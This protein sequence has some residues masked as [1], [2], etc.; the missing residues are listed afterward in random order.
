MQPVNRAALDPRCLSTTRPQDTL[1]DAQVELQGW[2]LIGSFTGGWDTRIIQATTNFDGM[3]RPA[4]YQAFVFYHGVFAGTLS[5]QEML[6]RTDGAL[7]DFALQGRG[8]DNGPVQITASFRRY[9]S[10]DALCCPSA[11]S[12][13]GY[14]II[15]ENGQPLVRPMQATTSPIGPG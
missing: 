3:C 10:E 8:V 2:L 4:S 13:V 14:T 1:E 11:N 7:G 6:S 9:K 12:S 5:P 15:L